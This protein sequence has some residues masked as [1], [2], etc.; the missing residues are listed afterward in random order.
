MYSVS[1]SAAAIVAGFANVGL[2][3]LP[4]SPIGLTVPAAAAA[5][6]YSGTLTVGNS[7]TGCTSGAAFTVTIIANPTITLGTN[8]SACAGA[9]S[10]T[11][12]YTATTGSPN[13]YSITYSAAA[14][15]AGFANVGL[16]TLPASPIGLTVPAGVAA[17]SYNGTLTVRNSTTGCSSGSSPFTVTIGSS[18]TFSISGPASVCSSTDT[19][20]SAPV[21]VTGPFDWNLVNL[22]GSA[23]RIQGPNSA[24]KNPIL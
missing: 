17:G 13:Q 6:T 15:S 23:A 7:A 2:T 1:Y 4:A 12:P 16:T 5:G 8:P 21:G 3:T 11:L 14:I 10:A 19:T 18:S 22:T 24:F 9:T 20:Y